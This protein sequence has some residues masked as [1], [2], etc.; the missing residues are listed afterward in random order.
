MKQMCLPRKGRSSL[1][2]EAQK[3]DLSD[4]REG[5]EAQSLRRVNSMPHGWPSLELSPS[6]SMRV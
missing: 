5:L 4:T 2:W 3:G 1:G 6:P